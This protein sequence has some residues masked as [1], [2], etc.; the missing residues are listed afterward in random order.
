MTGAIMRYALLIREDGRAVVG[1]RERSRRAAG[2][3]ALQA[4]LQERGELM[5]S[6]RLH[7]P[8][9]AA[10]V[11]CWDGGGI[12]IT[13]GAFGGAREQIT[14][15]AVATARTGTRRSRWRPGFPPRGTDPSR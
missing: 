6:E 12:V 9:A 14:G 15:F 8:E 5:G 3:A 2:L 7:P 11:R 1:P 13:N 4:E 10:T